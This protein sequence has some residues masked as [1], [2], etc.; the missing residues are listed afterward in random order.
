MAKGS[1]F[2]G[3]VSIGIVVSTIPTFTF[4]LKS[5]VV[6]QANFMPNPF[7]PAVG[8]YRGLYYVPNDA[9]VESS[10]SFSASVTSAGAFTARF[11][12][13]AVNY[14]Y[15]GVFK[16]DG[17]T[18]VKSFSRGRVLSPITVQ[19]Q[20]YLSGGPMTGTISDGTWTANL[21]A[22]PA[23]Y[24]RTN[25]AP[26]AGRYTMLIPGI[27]NSSGQPAGNGFA[28]VTVNTL[29]AV[30]LSGTMG[31]GTAFISSSA[32]GSEGQWPFYVSLYGGKGSMLG[33]LTF[34]TNGDINGQI[35]WFKTPQTTAKL[36]PGGFT[37]GTEVVGSTYKY[38]NGLPV[39]DFSDDTGTLSL[40]N[41][42]LAESIT[43]EVGLGI[44]PATASCTN[45]LTVMNASGMFHGTVI[46]PATK[47]PIAVSGIVLQKQNYGAGYFLGTNQCGSMSLSGPP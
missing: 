39:L 6:L 16:F 1:I 30:S 42:D 21:A 26:Q 41:G 38:T 9:S 29:G 43:N 33:W 36:Y 8:A 13:G 47:K 34:A 31:D 27:Y 5:N 44:L 4:L 18:A 22:N 19:L 17:T 3:W 37:N 15:A 24:S 20:L 11:G 10:G 28:S 25:L 7:I 12:L 32:V 2:T 14:S 23:I 35:D 46:N 45:K 40:I